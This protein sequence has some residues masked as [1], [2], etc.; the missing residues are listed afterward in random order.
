MKKQEIS[1]KKVPSKEI[2]KELRQFGSY[3]SFSD[4]IKPLE[5]IREKDNG[6]ENP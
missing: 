1:T 6:K 3:H 4:M 5:E 2:M